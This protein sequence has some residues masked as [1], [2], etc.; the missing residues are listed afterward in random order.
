MPA[1]SKSK[2]PSLRTLRRRF[3]AE[4]KVVND[5]PAQPLCH[6]ERCTLLDLIDEAHAS[7][8]LLVEDS[9]DLDE[10]RDAFAIAKTNLEIA[11]ADL[12]NER[13][14]NQRLHAEMAPLFHRLTA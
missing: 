1:K 12:A 5:A 10:A 2:T 11:E 4:Q 8:R 13:A 7:N 9:R 14:T 6:N 3:L